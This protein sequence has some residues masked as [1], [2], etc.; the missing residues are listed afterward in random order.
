MVVR[1]VEPGHWNATRHRVRSDRRQAL[2]GWFD[3]QIPED[4]RAKFIRLSF[5]KAGY[6]MQTVDSIAFSSVAGTTVGAT[7]DNNPGPFSQIPRLPCDG[8]RPD[9]P[10]VWYELLGMGAEVCKPVSLIVF[11]F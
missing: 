11:S 5:L 1:T 10:G 2:S 6:Q 9:G 7:M 3:L 8:V 4:M